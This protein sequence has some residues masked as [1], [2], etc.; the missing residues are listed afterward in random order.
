M[1]GLRQPPSPSVPGEA[2][3]PPQGQVRGGVPE[4]SAVFAVL[5]A[6]RPGED[7]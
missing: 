2:L 5:L 1:T 4:E 3:L 7:A 6:R